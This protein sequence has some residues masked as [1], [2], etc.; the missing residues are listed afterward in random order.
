MT[1]R[2]AMAITS[3]SLRILNLSG[4]LG[5][6]RY[7]SDDERSGYAVMRRFAV[8][9]ALA[10]ISDLDVSDNELDDLAARALA[11]SPYL[12][13]LKRLDWTGNGDDGGAGVDDLRDALPAGVLNTDAP[14]RR[15]NV[16]VLTL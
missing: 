13:G 14:K 7:A 2:E 10:G 5:V 6:E 12:G 8:M 11:R 1:S 3:P 15:G 16:V 4:T 9:P